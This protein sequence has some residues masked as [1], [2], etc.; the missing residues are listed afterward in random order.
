LGYPVYNAET[1]LGPALHGTVEDGKYSLTSDLFSAGGGTSSYQRQLSLTTTAATSSTISG[2]YVETITDLIQQDLAVRGVF[3]LTRSLDE[4]LAGFSAKPSTGPAPL[5]VEFLDWSL[6]DPTSWAWDFGDGATSS[7]QHP[8]HTY[9]GPG[10]YTVTLTVSNLFGSHTMT[11]TDYVSVTEPAAPVAYFSASPRSGLA[12]LAV[13]FWDLSPGGPTSWAWDF[14]DGGSSTAQN[15]KHTYDTAGTFTV[16]LTATNALGTDT[17]TEPGYITVTKA[18]EKVYL[19][20]VLRR[21]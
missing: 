18:E 7:Q 13:D 16:T 2:E 14:G 4:P 20:L 10:T 19:P 3:T 8:T 9:T 17:R 15:P 21:R 1:G 12:P 11:E 5:V 6:G